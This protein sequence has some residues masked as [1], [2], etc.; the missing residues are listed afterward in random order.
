M[1]C[2]LCS[3]VEDLDGSSKYCSFGVDAGMLERIGTA[4]AWDCPLYFRWIMR[5]YG[6]FDFNRTSV[7][8]RYLFNREGFTVTSFMDLPFQLKVENE[9]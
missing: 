3:L 4:K 5:T 2:L 6:L 7:S 1:P 8:S 9:F